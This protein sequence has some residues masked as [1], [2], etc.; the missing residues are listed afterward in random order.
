MALL[1]SIRRLPGA[2]KPTLAALIKWILIYFLYTK[3]V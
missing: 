2:A 3:H 1:S